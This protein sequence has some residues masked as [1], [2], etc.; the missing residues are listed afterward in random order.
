MSVKSFSA[1]GIK[2]RRSAMEDDNIVIDGFNG[3][4][5]DAY[6]GVYDGHGGRLAVDAIKKHLHA[7]FGKRLL[8]TPDNVEDAFRT[9]FLE[10][11]NVITDAGIVVSGATVVVCYLRG[12]ENGKRVLYTA[13]AGDSRA[14]VSAGSDAFQLSKDHKPTSEEE[15]MRIQSVGGWVANVKGL[16]RVNGILAVSRALGDIDMRPAITSE[17]YVS[18]SELTAQNEVLL[19]ASDGLWD[20]CRN[21]EAVNMAL[22]NL[23]SAEKIV[24]ILVKHAMLQHSSDNVT[25]VAAVL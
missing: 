10:M 20:V 3:V 23:D 2:G 21:W 7:I 14:V 16:H 24:Q 19:L 18:R 5:K 6:F 17:P 22:E 12:D 15:Q 1:M 11:D 9:S 13:N 8:E 25:V 4:E